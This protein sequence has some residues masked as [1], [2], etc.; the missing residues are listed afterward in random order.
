MF[1]AGFNGGGVQ[2]ALRK[3]YLFVVYKAKQSKPNQ[4]KTA[5]QPRK[6]LSSVVTFLLEW[7]LE[8]V[9][10]ISYNTNISVF[11]VS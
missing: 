6:Y 7:M 2:I 10:F 3:V 9:N 4:N 11:K 8:S 5:P 1:N